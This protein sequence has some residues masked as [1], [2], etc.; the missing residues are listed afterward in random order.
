MKNLE[1]DFARIGDIDDNLE[2]SVGSR[3][4]ELLP[5]F[6]VWDKGTRGENFHV[7]IE[8]GRNAYFGYGRN[9]AVLDFRQ[10]KM[11][12]DFLNRKPQRT[13][14]FSSH[15]DAILTLWNLSDSAIVVDETLPTPDYSTITGTDDNV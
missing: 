15:W 9:D 11:L 6:H 2:V 8:I 10:R 7:R 1:S 14:A 13:D 3:N 4:G 12:V 5:H